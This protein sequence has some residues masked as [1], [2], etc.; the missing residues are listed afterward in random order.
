MNATN[1]VLNE[2]ARLVANGTYTNVET[3]TKN[4]QEYRVIKNEKGTA[5]LCIDLYDA[6]QLYY[7]LREKADTNRE[8]A[9]RELEKNYTNVAA[10]SAERAANCDRL[11]DLLAAEDCATRRE[12][13]DTDE[14]AE[15]IETAAPVV[16]VAE[17]ETP[18]TIDE[19]AAPAAGT[20]ARAAR[21]FLLALTLTAAPA[22]DLTADETPA[23]VAE[24]Y[25]ADPLAEVAALQ[26]AGLT[27][28]H[29][30]IKSTPTG[31]TPAADVPALLTC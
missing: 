29:V 3:I 30:T 1:K 31:P 20:I 16:E 8:N 9:A 28:A 27:V 4:W 23:E 7:M 25:T 5:Y 12:N 13:A 14:T 22:A 24:I 17:A 19:T 2:A 21:V 10:V 11:A 15:T 26:A 18:D 6:A